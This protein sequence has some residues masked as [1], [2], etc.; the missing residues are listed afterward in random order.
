MSLMTDSAVHP[1]T[2]MTETT[3]FGVAQGAVE[4][5]AQIV[6]AAAL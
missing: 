5:A 1:N 6:D 3:A 4:T 2:P